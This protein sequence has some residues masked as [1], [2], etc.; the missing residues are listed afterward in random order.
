MRPAAKRAAGGCCRRHCCRADFRAGDRRTL[1]RRAV[2][3]SAAE[4]SADFRAGVRQAGERASRSAPDRSTG[5]GRAECGGPQ[6]TQPENAAPESDRPDANGEAES[7]NLSRE[8]WTPAHSDR[9][10]AP[11]TAGS[12]GRVRAAAPGLS[13]LA[14]KHETLLLI[15]FGVCN[16]GPIATFIGVFL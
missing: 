9:G 5:H 13:H 11:R 10:T 1:D 12:T 15:E 7:A 4:R 16:S 3:G 2:G 6:S 14:A 8:S